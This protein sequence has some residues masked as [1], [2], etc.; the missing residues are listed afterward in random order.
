M[1]LCILETFYILFCF[2]LLYTFALKTKILLITSYILWLELS[3][4]SRVIHYRIA[5][6]PRHYEGWS[7]IK[8]LD[9]PVVMGI[10]AAACIDNIVIS[11]F[12]DSTNHNTRHLKHICNT[13][14]H[15]R[16]P[17]TNFC[18]FYCLSRSVPISS[19]KQKQS[20]S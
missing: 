6:H 11:D 17:P 9:A 19:C 3:N 4:Y 2:T 7:K 18:P 1:Q 14:L 13:M 5:R 8:L 12:F 16:C 15:S 10:K 20:L